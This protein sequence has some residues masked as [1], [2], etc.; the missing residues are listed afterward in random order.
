MATCPSDLLNLLGQYGPGG[1]CSKTSLGFLAPLRT[2]RRVRFH[3]QI[4]LQPGQQWSVEDDYETDEGS[5]FGYFLSAL[6]ELGYSLSYATLDAQYF[7]LAQ[8]RDR[9]FLSEVLETGAVHQRYYLTSKACLGIL[10]RA[11]KRGNEL[12]KKGRAH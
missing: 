4:Y 5:D 6:L 10:R 3:R 8:R 2:K 12:P 11:E 7:G 1:C 9:L